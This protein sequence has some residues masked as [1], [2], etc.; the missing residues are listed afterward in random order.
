MKE[1]RK[2][3]TSGLKVINYRDI[4]RDHPHHYY[5]ILGGMWGYRNDLQ[6]LDITKLMMTF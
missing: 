3:L 5:K 1:R 6:K 2:L 4:M